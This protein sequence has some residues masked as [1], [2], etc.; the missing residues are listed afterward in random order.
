MAETE[1]KNG[2]NVEELESI[3][4]ATIKLSKN[5]MRAM[6]L[7]YKAPQTPAQI[8]RNERNRERFKQKHEEYNRKKAEFEEN[9]LKKIEKSVNVKLKPKQKYNYETVEI[10]LINDEN[11]EESDD[12]AQF[13]AYKAKQKEKSIQKEKPVKKEKKVVVKDETSSE[14]EYIQKKTKKATKI[15]ETVSK[16]DEAIN[17]ISVPVN[18]YLALFNKK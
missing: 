13:L 7:T 10:P 12:Y 15:L 4:G 11:D 1:D 3:N 16:L 6:G 9:Q 2:K 14:D 5:Q 8:A 18:P 17:K